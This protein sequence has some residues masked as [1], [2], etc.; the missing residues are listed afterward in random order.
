MSDCVF[1][2]FAGPEAQHLE[3]DVS[4]YR[5]AVLNAIV[6]CCR[7]QIVCQRPQHIQHKAEELMGILCRNRENKMMEVEIKKI[8]NFKL[9]K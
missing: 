5:A 8:E 2:P 4:I 6:H 1:I 7:L 9:V 3:C